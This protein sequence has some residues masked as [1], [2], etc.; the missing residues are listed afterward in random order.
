MS[1]SQFECAFYAES[2]WRL[3]RSSNVDE[4]IAIAATLRNHVI[5]RQGAATEYKS[6]TD[7]CEDFLRLC[8]IRDRPRMDEPALISY[9]D[10]LLCN[11][12]QI[13]DCSALDITSTQ[14]NPRGAKYFC[15]VAELT[16]GDWF[17]TEIVDKPNLHPLIGAFGSQNFYG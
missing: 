16:Q 10:G 4:L 2:V 8:P 11:I 14:A 12:E 7:V 5:A 13:Y 17:K 9:P 1:P 3:A 6:F 15:R